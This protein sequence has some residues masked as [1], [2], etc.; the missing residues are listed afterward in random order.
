MMSHS[1]NNHYPKTLLFIFI[2]LWA[3]SAIGIQFPFDFFLE[4]ILTVFV[5][6][7]LILT[8]KNFRL[9][10]LSYTLIFCFML[11]HILGAHYTYS[12]VPYDQWSKELFGFSIDTYFGFT[13]NMYDRLVHFSFGLLFAYPVREFF[14]RI[15]AT[16]GIWSYYLPLDVMAS[17]SVLYELMEFAVAVL[18]GGDIAANYNGEQGDKWDAHKDM[19]MA[20]T[21]GI[22]AMLTTFFVNLKYKKDFWK[23][24]KESFTVRRKTPLG[25]VELRRMRKQ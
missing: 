4:H 24:M 8:Y 19:L 7:L 17:F 11:L 23:D 9:S 5:L 16:R 22:V 13:R 6:A 1:Q 2:F 12:L 15:V 10:N 18:L 20:I 3:I 14:M 21:G 25:E